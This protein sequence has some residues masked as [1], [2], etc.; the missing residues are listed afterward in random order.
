[1]RTFIVL[2]QNGVDAVTLITA[3]HMSDEDVRKLKRLVHKKHDLKVVEVPMSIM[4]CK[5][6]DTL[7][8]LEKVLV[9][10]PHEAQ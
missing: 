1:M 8:A 4:S 10:T 9:G 2:E 5:L 3:D 6:E 7:L